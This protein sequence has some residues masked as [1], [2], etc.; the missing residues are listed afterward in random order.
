MHFGNSKVAY[1]LVAAGLA[2]AARTRAALE[3][4]NSIGI[5]LEPLSDHKT[6]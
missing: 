1:Y 6:W 3:I 2:R 5:Y 4:R